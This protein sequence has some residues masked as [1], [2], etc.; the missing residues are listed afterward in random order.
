MLL[1]S[2]AQGKQRA[3]N[4]GRGKA[5]AAAAADDKGNKEKTKTFALRGRGGAPG[6]HPKSTQQKKAEPIP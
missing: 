2:G 1:Q 3:E 5:E 4:G 6:A